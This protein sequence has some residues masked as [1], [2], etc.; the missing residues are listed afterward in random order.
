MQSYS[1]QKRRESST[2]SDISTLCPFGSV[3]ASIPAG[4]RPY[5]HLSLSLCF[6]TSIHPC[7]SKSLHPHLSAYTDP[8]YLQFETS[9]HGRC[10]DVHNS[11]RL[12]LSLHTE[13]PAYLPPLIEVRSGPSFPKDGRIRGHRFAFCSATALGGLEQNTDMYVCRCRSNIRVGTDMHTYIYVPFIH[14]YMRACIY[15]F[16][17]PYIYRPNTCMH[18]RTCERI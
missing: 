5:T 6:S 11:T 13:R 7:I 12:Y 18:Q 17:F 2:G 14:A 3:H 10:I 4:I 8:A 16:T 9:I 1:D 15:T